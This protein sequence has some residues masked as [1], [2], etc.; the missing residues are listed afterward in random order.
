MFKHV[1]DLTTAGD[2]FVLVVYVIEMRT[3][4]VRQAKFVLHAEGKPTQQCWRF[5][6]I[7]EPHMND[8]VCKLKMVQ[9]FHHKHV[10]NMPD[11]KSKQ[12]ALKRLARCAMV[13][14]GCRPEF[15]IV[16]KSVETTEIACVRR[17][18]S[19]MCE[20]LHPSKTITLYEI[21]AQMTEWTS[22]ASFG[23]KDLI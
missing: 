12:K 7:A 19:E 9:S 22:I 8:A 3:G 18:E 10:L 2:Q 1:R 5:F 16:L 15:G 17:C 14:T 21:P 20:G 23:G 4:A 6:R 11:Q 13:A